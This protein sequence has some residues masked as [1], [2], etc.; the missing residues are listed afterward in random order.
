MII[1]LKTK[2]CSETTKICIIG[3][4][5]VGLFLAK[6][7]S[8]KKIHTI[9][10]EEGKEIQTKKTNTK[11]NHT[12]SSELLLEQYT[13]KYSGLGGTSKVWGGQ[14]I[15]FQ[16]SDIQER[17]YIGVKSWNIKYEE[18]SKYF[19]I[20]SKSLK[21][22]FL[23]QAY[24]KKKTKNYNLKKTNFDL[25]FSVFLKN[26][27]KN[28]YNL[29]N[30]DLKDSQINIYTNA[31]VIKINNFNNSTVKNIIAKSSNGNLLKINADIVVIC[32]GAIESTKL[33]LNYNKQ[34]N[35]FITNQK[36]PLGH[37]LC[38]QLQCISAKI[39]IKN[40][41]KF[42][43]YFSPIYKYG[44]IHNP[45]LELK[46]KFQKKNNLPGAYC[47]ILMEKR[48]NYLTSL[49]KRLNNKKKINLEYIFIIIKGFF[50]IIKD[51]YNLFYFRILNKKTWFTEQSSALLFINI[52]Q[53]SNFY[54]KLSIAYKKNR[55]Y[56]YQK[57]LINYKINNK[58][59]QYIK[60]INNTFN[61]YWTNSGLNEI[62]KIKFFKINNVN[63]FKQTNHITGTLRM[64]SKKTNS[65]VNKNL[66][67]WGSN[68]LYICSTAVF[69]NYGTANTGFCLLAMTER[70]GNHLIE[71]INRNY[72]NKS[73]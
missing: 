30:K 20:I 23:E 9:I 45:R 40:W 11:Y 10:V 2:K 19:N 46:K 18:I 65:V 14:M 62:A 51:I 35:N 60:F 32:C 54:N 12:K 15:P 47:H 7:L 34:N 73:S 6:K 63:Y 41:K 61:N 70:L 29:F 1:D 38:E 39:I 42:V 5:T 25:R 72:L 68:N 17:N 8:E 27:V 22:K 56:D 57:L 37:F 71:K 13:K 36:I 21:L 48:N 3:G 43:L 52:E 50:K 31:Q 59:F 69:P 28:F 33:L 44:L 49:L 67:L 66:K 4:G 16:K 53:I 24:I 55:K 58:Y 64:G 26:K